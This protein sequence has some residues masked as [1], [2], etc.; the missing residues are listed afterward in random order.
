MLPIG[1]LLFL[2]VFARAVLPLRARLR[3]KLLLTIP[4]ALAAFKFH[5]LRLIGGPQFYSPDVSKPVLLASSWL[6]GT[7]LFFCVLLIAADVLYLLGAILFRKFRTRSE[8]RRLRRNRLNLALLLSAAAL[9]TLGIVNALAMPEVREKTVAVHALPPED[10]GLTIAVIADIHVDALTSPGR[11]RE[12][13]ERTNA[14]KPDLIV[15][16]GDFVD[17]PVARLG[18]MMA[19]LADLSAKYGVY[20]VPGNHEYYNNYEQ[21]KQHFSR[22]GIRMLDNEHVLIA[23]GTIALGGVTDSAAGR[24][25]LE[26]PDIRKAFDGAPEGAIRIL[27]CHRPQPAE[28]A[29]KEQV[30]LQISGHTHGGMVAGL[31]M[32]VASHNGG[33]VSGLYNVNGTVLFVSNGAGLWSGFPFRLGVPSEIALLRLR[34]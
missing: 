9:S 28:E 26:L 18:G 12:I 14:L 29:A 7:L 31:D 23:N 25:K 13:V 34:R 10:D 4:V 16:A 8:N 21:W 5:V 17:G 27:L 19:P 32:L 6:F 33:F 30:A 3:W 2:Y 24:P 22:L 1:F 15:L 11:V 20:G